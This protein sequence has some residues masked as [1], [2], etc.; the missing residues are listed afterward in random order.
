M[1]E[2]EDV[3]QDFIWK[4]ADAIFFFFTD[5]LLFFYLG[6]VLLLSFVIMH[7]FSPSRRALLVGRESGKQMEGKKI[8]RRR[9]ESFGVR[10]GN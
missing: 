10:N 3:E 1:Q 5:F 8:E 7:C 2:R 4:I 6:D 9:R